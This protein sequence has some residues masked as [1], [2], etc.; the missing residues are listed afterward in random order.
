VS[1]VPDLSGIV[2]RDVSWQH[3][4]SRFVR[5]AQNPA[6]GDFVDRR[7]HFV[8]G[9]YGGFRP[10]VGDTRGSDRL[11]RVLFRLARLAADANS[12]D[13]STGIDPASWALCTHVRRGGWRWTRGSS[14]SPH[15]DRSMVDL[16]GRRASRSAVL[17]VAFSE[18]RIRGSATDHCV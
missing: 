7:N 14:S 18:S 9:I 8:Y 16:G 15:H 5:L 13:M 10:M 12:A 1:A 3:L 4:G 6:G 11:P 17:R 2:H